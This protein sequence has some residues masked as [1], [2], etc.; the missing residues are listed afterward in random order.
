MFK[1]EWKHSFI[2]WLN[3]KYFLGFGFVTFDSEDAVERVIN[4]YYEN[5]IDGKWV[6][7]YINGSINGLTE[8]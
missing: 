6:S 5:K 2:F 1:E 7:I 4:R 3:N 8:L